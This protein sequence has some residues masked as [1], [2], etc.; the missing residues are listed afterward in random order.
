MADLPQSPCKNIDTK[1][2]NFFLT[3][4]PMNDL[5]KG[6][7]DIDFFHRYFYISK[8]SYSSYYKIL[9]KIDSKKLF[10]SGRDLYGSGPTYSINNSALNVG[11]RRA[12]RHPLRAAGFVVPAVAINRSTYAPVFYHLS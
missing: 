1:K 9:V 11:L 5:V 2:L 3:H 6:Q 10:F 12:A 4:R 8:R 7:R